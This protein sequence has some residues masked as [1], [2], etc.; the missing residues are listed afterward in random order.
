MHAIVMF[1]W[2]GDAMFQWSGGAMAADKCK[3]GQG[4]VSEQ[5]IFLLARFAPRGQRAGNQLFASS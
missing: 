4:G 5:V 1:Q 2:S 3:P